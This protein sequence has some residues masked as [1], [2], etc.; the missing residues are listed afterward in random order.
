MEEQIAPF[1]L[2]LYQTDALTD[3]LPD[4][5]VEAAPWERC[6]ALFLRQIFDHSRSE[7]SVKD[8]RRTLLTFFTGS[9]HG[10]PPK[11]PEDYTREDV[12]DF[13]H[14]PSTS[15]RNRGGAPAVATMNQRLS[16]LSSFYTFAATFT[17]TG[18]DGRPQ[19]LL[20]RPS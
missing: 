10:G 9:A 14:R 8:Y 19:V 1:A 20:Q 6:M 4:G 11:H 12:E 13:L 16:I 17:I 7:K 15:L 2:E 5:R 3:W 18:P